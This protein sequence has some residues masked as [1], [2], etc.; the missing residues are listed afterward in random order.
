MT[1]AKHRRPVVL[2]LE[3]EAL[4]DAP[5]PADAPPVGEPEPAAAEKALAA[6]R[7][8]AKMSALARLFWG[9]LA[10]LIG[11]ALALTVEG[12]L[13]ELF[14]RDDWLG[15]IG[16][17]L[18]ALVV[19]ALAGMVLRELAGLARLEKIGRFRAG[20]RR[21]LEGGDEGA[22]K[23]V[24]AGLA[25]L[26]AARPELAQVAER[27]AGAAEET[28]D[29]AARLEVAER[30]WMAPLDAQAERVLARSGR[31]VA[32]A[33]AM[34][35]LPVVD[36]LAVLVLNLRM[37]RGVA[38]IYGGR[39]GWLESWRLLRA[40]AAHLAA[41]GVI[42]ATDDVLGP[43]V[44]G[45]VLSRLSRRFGEATVN[46]A[47]TVRVGVAAVEVCRPLPFTAL[48]PPRA[49]SVLMRALTDWRAR[50]EE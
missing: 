1:R 7:R 16:V 26:Y 28:P 23:A 8:P 36:V 39:A 31:N 11:L 47:L 32:G 37:I 17:G 45:G 14:A 41:T 9:G 20:A 46:A 6:A 12:F 21:A 50:A 42:A 44:G 48:P 25:R 35:P 24:L 5:S 34:I 22:A 2:D 18:F 4:P 40:V 43:L 3:A 29:A 27:M 19:L 15:W 33:T 13:R 30:L 10:A 38:E 49:R